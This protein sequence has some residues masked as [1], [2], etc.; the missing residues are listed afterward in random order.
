ME[1][2]PRPELPNDD[3]SKAELHRRRRFFDRLRD[4]QHRK[5]ETL[6]E[7]LEKEAG[8]SEL[9][10]R[11]DENLAAETEET[12]LPLEA[13]EFRDR[14]LRLQQVG[15]AVIAKA[16]DVGDFAESVSG[17]IEGLP[18]ENRQQIAAEATR[19]GEA[20]EGLAEAANELDTELDELD[21]SLQES[22]KD[23]APP[24]VDSRPETYS[25]PE[26]PA[27]K[28]EDS[29]ISGMARLVV[30]T[31][32]GG[33]LGALV[34]AGEERAKN[35]QAA[36]EKTKSDAAL[37]QQRQKLARHE[38]EL[39]ALKAQKLEASPPAEQKE[40]VKN[41]SELAEKQTELTRSTTEQVRSAVQQTAEY[42]RTYQIPEQRPVQSERLGDIETAERLKAALAKKDGYY[43]R[44]NGAANAA[45]AS[46]QPNPVPHVSQGF[47][48]P[49]DQLKKQAVMHRTYAVLLVAAVIIMLGLLLF[50]SK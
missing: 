47:N 39:R 15:R 36:K 8:V 14:L 18:A 27:E 41:T 20:T 17:Q 35:R 37:E 42:E 11:T 10:Q 30:A 46:Q 26:K 43:A 48:L 23:Q 33:G 12:E 32:V 34:G 28:P 3:E 7:D 49:P 1:Q 24:V 6:K 44:K 31:L 38:I 25:Q 2:T 5:P 4:W 16:R 50:G 29:G 13:L 22:P 45:L 19:L 21:S 40:Y 9:W